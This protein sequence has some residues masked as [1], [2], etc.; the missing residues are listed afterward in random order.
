MRLRKLISC[1]RSVQEQS[2]LFK[3]DGLSCKVD[4]STKYFKDLQ[5]FGNKSLE[6]QTEKQIR[7]GIRTADKRIAEHER[8]IS[9]PAAIYGEERWNQM[10]EIERRGAINH[11]RGDIDD[12]RKNQADGIEMLKKKGWWHGD[13]DTGR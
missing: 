12:F 5:L 4:D 2:S 3:F 8:K 13:E 10:N 1:S 6:T 11:W 7:K 9:N